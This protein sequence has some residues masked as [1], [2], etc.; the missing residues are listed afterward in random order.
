MTKQTIPLA[1]AAPPAA[2][3]PSDHIAGGGWPGLCRCVSGRAGH[4][5]AGPGVN[6]AG[7]EVIA[8]YARR[9]R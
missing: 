1:P 2:Q 6:A 5:Q 7:A 3:P 8:A 4:R 9:R